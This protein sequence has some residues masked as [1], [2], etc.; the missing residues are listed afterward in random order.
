M[1]L[2][3]ALVTPV[4]HDCQTNLKE[5]ECDADQ[6]SCSWRLGEHAVY[7]CELRSNLWVSG[8]F[9]AVSCGGFVLVLVLDCTRLGVQDMARDLKGIVIFLYALISHILFIICLIVTLAT[10]AGSTLGMPTAFTVVTIVLTIV[11]IG[12]LVPLSP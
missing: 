2:V 7:T 4:N 5:S 8:F 10:D 11:E 9:S 1:L 12:L 3:L 6:P